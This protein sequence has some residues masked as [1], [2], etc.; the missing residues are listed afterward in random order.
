MFKK[1]RKPYI[2]KN[3]DDEVDRLIKQGALVSFTDHNTAYIPIS[4]DRR[5]Y[6]PMVKCWTCKNKFPK[7]LDKTRGT[8]Q[9]YKCP[10]CVKKE[11][12]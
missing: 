7:Y 6:I 2:H 3:I 12:I 4:E 1:V 11:V 9:L 5:F 8:G 10:D